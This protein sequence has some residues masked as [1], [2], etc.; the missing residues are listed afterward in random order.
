LESFALTRVRARIAALV[1]VDCTT[2]V[3]GVAP[4]QKLP[5]SITAGVDLPPNAL[6][7]LT[8]K[9]CRTGGSDRAPDWQRIAQPERLCHQLLPLSDARSGGVVAGILVWIE[10]VRGRGSIAMTY[11]RQAR[12]HFP[13]EQSLAT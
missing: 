1:C 9:D 12:K 2:A 13:A 3:Q 5:S 7:G 6:D 8:V 4:L 11:V 10:W